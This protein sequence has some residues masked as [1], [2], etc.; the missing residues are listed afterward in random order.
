MKPS[1]PRS[2]PD[3]WLHDNVSAPSQIAWPAPMAHVVH[4]LG[5]TERATIRIVP[6]STAAVP[7]GLGRISEAL[8]RI[9][10]LG[11]RRVL[12]WAS[13]FYVAKVLQASMFS[14]HPMSMRY[15]KRGWEAL[16]SLALHGYLDI[17]IAA[18]PNQTDPLHFRPMPL[19]D[20]LSELAEIA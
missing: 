17:E 3:V 12:P 4:K 5:A 7:L 1:P 6:P 15:A 20:R 14:M 13:A 9:A 19:S 16:A 11:E 2:V 10:L 18:T 8:F